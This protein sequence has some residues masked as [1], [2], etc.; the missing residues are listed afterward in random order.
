[1]LENNLPRPCSRLA[2]V[3]G[4][5]VMFIFGWKK[6]GNIPR[7]RNVVVIAAPH[8]SNW[9]FVFLIAA[10]YSFG[11]SIN[12]LGKDSLF[13][14]P[15]SPIFRFL[16]GIPVNRSEPGNLVKTITDRIKGDLGI[17][18]VVP[19]SGT[20]KKPIIGSLDFIE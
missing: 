3:I 16:G 17:A 19:P 1:M 10:A 2:K 9:D 18:I 6:A 15:L 5:S 12:W 11:F 14:T 7:H 4:T 20:R 8:T 13:K